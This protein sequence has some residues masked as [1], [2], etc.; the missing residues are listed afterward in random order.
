M[1]NIINLFATG[2]IDGTSLNDLFLIGKAYNATLNGFAGND[3]INVVYS[4]NSLLDGGEGNDTLV[5]LS[6]GP[7]VTTMIGGSGNDTISGSFGNFAMYGD[8]G[9]SIGPFPVPYFFQLFYPNGG[10]VQEVVITA[11]A[12]G[13][14]D[15]VMYAGSGGDFMS[16]DAGVVENQV[17]FQTAQ[18]STNQSLSMLFELTLSIAKFGNDTLYGGSGN[19]VI[20]GDADTSAG[21]SLSPD[22]TP[23]ATAIANGTNSIATALF[24]SDKNQF[25]FGADKIFGGDGND[26]IN[27]DLSVDAH[28][29]AFGVATAYN[30]GHA[31]SIFQTSEEL[32]LYGNDTISGGNG[33]DIIY[34]DGKLNSHDALGGTA[35]ADGV[36]SDARIIDDVGIDVHDHVTRLPLINTSGNDVINGDAGNDTIYGDHKLYFN[37]AI[38]GTATAL[39]GGIAS[40]SYMVDGSV[41][42]FGK[43]TLS[44]GAGNDKIVGDVLTTKIE[45]AQGTAIG[46]GASVAVSFKNFGQTMGDDIISGGAGN[47]MI[48]GDALE[49]SLAYA[50]LSLSTVAGHVRVADSNNN[51]ITWGNDVM[52]A[53]GGL[54]NFITAV[55]LSTNNK[56]VA[57]GFDVIKDFNV[58]DDVLTF[59][60]TNMSTLL[61]HTSLAYNSGDTILKF[62]GGAGGSI[63]LQ[64]IHV[65]SMADLHI[66]VLANA[67]TLVGLFPG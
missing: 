31:T 4:I 51:S 26:V 63:T 6:S 28:E 62:D 42:T 9:N 1:A 49:F 43:D 39:N 64:D 17:I 29:V 24:Y 22:S 16:G 13:F 10:A 65:N 48:V 55:A 47:D 12:T 38:G 57:Q 58:C 60:G 33:N 15:D 8:A 67:S 45:V 50:G 41:I 37:E 34:G 53:G 5:V 32:I 20:V 18:T 56:L 19:D 66:N 59:V 7:G 25:L 44:G 11:P 61:N 52:S 36:G 3:S 40:S 23:G 30:G 35:Y 54:D 27:G 21:F 2:E 14:G 46:A